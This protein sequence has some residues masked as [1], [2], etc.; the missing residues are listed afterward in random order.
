MISFEKLVK[1]LDTFQVGPTAGPEM[2]ITLPADLCVHGP[3]DACNT[4]IHIFFHS[5]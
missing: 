1:C 2:N 5:R 3:L 4:K